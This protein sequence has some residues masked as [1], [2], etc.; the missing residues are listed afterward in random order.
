[1]AEYQLKGGVTLTD[2]G[3]ERMSDAAAKGDYPGNPEH[4]CSAPKDG[5]RSATRRP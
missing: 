1:M 3:F 5:R 4:G 2:A